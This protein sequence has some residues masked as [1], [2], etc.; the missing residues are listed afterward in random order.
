MSTAVDL[1]I[2]WKRVHETMRNR[3][4]GEVTSEVGLAGPDLSVLAYLFGAGGSAR[5]NA[6]A[7]GLGWDRTRLSHLLTRMEE[8]GYVTR[9]KLTN[10]VEVTIGPKGRRQLEASMPTLEAAAHRHLLAKLD[11]GDAEHLRRILERLLA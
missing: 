9:T 2:L 1:W 4:V 7:V 10:G 11:D 3:I 6:I 5:Q 8:R